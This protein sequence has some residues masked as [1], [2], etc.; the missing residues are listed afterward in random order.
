M[1]QN[2]TISQLYELSEE[3]I[4]RLKIWVDEK[5]YFYPSQDPL[6]S[7]GQMIEFLD[8]HTFFND[9]QITRSD[10]GWSFDFLPFKFFSMEPIKELCDAL[11]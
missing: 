7:I 5:K 11:W 9:R 4:D 8:E 3:N 1:K 10:R 6:L 2:I